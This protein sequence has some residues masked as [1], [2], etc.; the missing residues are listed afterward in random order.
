MPF[1]PI[2]MFVPKR[3]SKVYFFVVKSYNSNLNCN[4]N[5]SIMD[6]HGNAV[7][8]AIAVLLCMGVT[9][10]ES[11]GLGGGSMIVIYNSRI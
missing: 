8:A 5:R 10:P 11:M 7:D 2:L 1:P 9:I 6:E 4:L 3:E